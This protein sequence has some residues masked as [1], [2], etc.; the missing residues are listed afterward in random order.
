MPF[1]AANKVPEV[2]S[3]ATEWEGLLDHHRLAD[4]EDFQSVQVL[5]QLA[6]LRV[7]V[8]AD[9]I[10]VAGNRSRN[11]AGHACPGSQAVR[12]ESDCEQVPLIVIADGSSKSGDPAARDVRARAASLIERYEL[13]IDEP[14]QFPG[15]PIAGLSR[16]SGNDW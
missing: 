5:R 2:R 14:S 8:H 15:E 7:K 13:A 4:L 9:E 1:G 3:T 11:K 12:Q 10:K 16:S 6:R